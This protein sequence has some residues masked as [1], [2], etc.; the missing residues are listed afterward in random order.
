[1]LIY[2]LWSLHDDISCQLLSKI[3]QFYNINDGGCLLL[4]A[5][6]LEYLNICQFSWH[7]HLKGNKCTCENENIAHKLPT[8]IGPMK[9]NVMEY[10]TSLR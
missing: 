5:F 4:I 8:N 3:H 9:L 2:V 6:P 1:M 7:F 10:I